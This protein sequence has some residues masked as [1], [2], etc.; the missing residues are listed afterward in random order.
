[1]NFL[2]LNLVIN[3]YTTFYSKHIVNFIKFFTVN[4]RLSFPCLVHASEMP[5]YYVTMHMLQY[6]SRVNEEQKNEISIKKCV[7]IL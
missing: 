1:M 6:C 4:E 7:Q 2:F 5:Q 3:F